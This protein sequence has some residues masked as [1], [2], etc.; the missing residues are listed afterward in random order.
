ML[1]LKAQI[2]QRKIFSQISEFSKFFLIYLSFFS[3]NLK[4]FRSLHHSKKVHNFTQ[5]QGKKTLNNHHN[6]HL[7]SNLIFKHDINI[8]HTVLYCLWYSFLISISLNKH[9]CN[10]LWRIEKYFIRNTI[11]LVT[12]IALDKNVNKGN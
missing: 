10:I 3:A 12:W 5:F 11:K 6:K 8:I 4:K 1:F 2:S 7:K 9:I